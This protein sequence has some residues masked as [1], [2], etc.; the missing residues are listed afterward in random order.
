MQGKNSEAVRAFEDAAKATD[1]GGRVWV[2]QAMGLMR[3]DI[4]LVSGTEA[5]ALRYARTALSESSLRPITNHYLGMVARW[6]AV[7][8]SRNAGFEESAEI[9]DELWAGMHSFDRLDC[10]EVVAARITLK[11]SSGV[12]AVS[13]RRDLAA[14]LG[15][16]PSAIEIQLRRFGVLN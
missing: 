3:A 14:R 1:P 10:A 2:T 8:A 12:G 7:L 16:L 6:H 9:L 4:H 13:E 5:D 11:E 15:E